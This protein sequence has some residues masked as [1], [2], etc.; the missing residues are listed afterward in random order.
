MNIV[1]PGNKG[2]VTFD[3]PQFADLGMKP[4]I[5]D[6]MMTSAERSRR[7]AAAVLAELQS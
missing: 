7:L 1:T 4:L 2:H 5:A 3:P 6:T